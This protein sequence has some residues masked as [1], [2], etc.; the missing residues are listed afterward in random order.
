M[1]F[2]KLDLTGTESAIV[3]RFNLPPLR[4]LT[5]ARCIRHR[6][7]SPRLLTGGR[8]LR[9]TKK[10]DRIKT[11]GLKICDMNRVLGS[12]D[13][14]NCCNCTIK[15]RQLRLGVSRVARRVDDVEGNIIQLRFR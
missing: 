4:R 7:S 9:L 15:L 6:G 14:L 12:A 8:R 3:A 10:F 2:Y 13:A 5:A 1:A 11:S